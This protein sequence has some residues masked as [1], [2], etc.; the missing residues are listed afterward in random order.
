MTKILRKQIQWLN[1]LG[2]AEMQFKADIPSVVLTQPL[3]PCFDRKQTSL[4]LM[5]L[6]LITINIPAISAK[7]CNCTEKYHNITWKYCNFT[8]K[9][10][11]LYHHQHLHYI[12]KRNII[13]LYGNIIT[14][15]GNIITS[16][17][18]ITPYHQQLAAISGKYYNCNHLLEPKN[19]NTGELIVTLI[20]NSFV[21]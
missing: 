7:Y 16:H 5:H 8:C 19:L 2:G 9:Y 17:G 13:P 1:V 11:T 14:S 10:Y 12:W 6:S 4:A 3:P 18:N 15:H 21:I 20:L